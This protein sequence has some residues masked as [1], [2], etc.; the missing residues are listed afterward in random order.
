VLWGVYFGIILMLEKTFVLGMLKRLPAAVGHIY[1][2]LL[3]MFGWLI[4]S[5]SSA[6]EI[7]RYLKM[8]FGSGAA[9]TTSVASY[10]FLRLLP[11]FM[12][13]IIA[14]TPLIKSLYHRLNKRFAAAA[15][16]NPALMGG[17]LLLCTAYMVDSTFS[18]FLYYI[19]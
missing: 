7:W 16:L 8:M 18:P 11:L 13:S 12:V 2:L 1:S 4:F 19:F 14:S 9:L 5:S 3:I 17:S 6:A 10:D 15:Y